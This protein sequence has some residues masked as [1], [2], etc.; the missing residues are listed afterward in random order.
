MEMLLQD[1]RYGLRILAKSPAFTAVAV[2]TLALGIGMTTAIFSVVYGVLLRPL[3][4]D[5]PEQIVQL[6][7]VNAQGRQMQF[8]DPNFEDVRSE[9]RTLQGAAEYAN[10]VLSVSGGTEPTRTMVGLVSR[11]F[12]PVLHVKPILGRGFSAEDQRF[13]AVP[14]ALLGYGYW[15]QFLGGTTDFGSKKLRID[16]RV[17][18]IIG[19][20]PPRF[21]FPPAAEIWVPREIYVR[22]PSRTA[23]NWQVIGR[24]RDGISIAEARAELQTIAT[25]LKQQYGQ[26]TMMVSVAIAPLL[27]AMTTDVRP[28]LWILLGAVGFLLLIA[29][30][31]VANLLL[32]QS[33]ARQHEIAVRFALGATR[34]RVVRQL[35]AEA[36]LLSLV[37]GMLGV[38]AAFWGLQ[39]LVALSPDVLPRLS[40]VSLSVPVLVFSMGLCVMVALALGLF[41]GLRS[42]S[43]LQHALSAGGRSQAGSLVSQ[44]MSRAI[45]AGQLAI[46][47]TLLAGAALLGRSLLRVL[48]I[49]PG[50]RTEHVIT[51]ELSLPGDVVLSGVDENNSKGRRVQFLDE[52]STRLRGIPGVEEV[53]GTTNLP[54]TG[55]HPD[56]TYIM[57]SPGET[58]PSNMQMLE[59]MFHDRSRTGYAEYSAVSDGYFRVL[60]IPLLRGRL[61]DARDT[62]TAPHVALISESL[63]QEKWPHEDPLG[64]QLEF[65]NMDG[66]LHL[67]TVVGVVGDVRADNLEHAA[68]P[69]IYVDYRQRPQ[70]TSS[71]KL[72]MRGSGDVSSVI[73]AARQI[74]RELDPEIPPKF[75]TLDQVVSGSVQG[76]RFNV[77]LLGVFAGTALLLALAG[78]YGVMAYSVT[79][80]TNEIGVRMALGASRTKILRLVLEQGLMTAAIGIA[81]GIVASV[82]VTRTISS[83][84]FGLSAMDPVTFVGVGLLLAAVAL[85]A[86]YI[87][88]RR[89]AK[90]DPMVALR[91]E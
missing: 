58:L 77:T 2:I 64:H 54:L 65:G 83:L 7:E 17:F 80:R 1:V 32:A 3:G 56:G 4:Y 66:D 59:Q 29:C 50:F 60:A 33:A 55:F 43:G 20:L 13:G 27:Q 36:L 6:H 12:L 10:V 22:Y 16:D 23:H 31:N 14:V 52:M 8:A 37:G 70:A 81:V 85:L 61:F 79:R 88:A 21:S 75:A 48:S 82:A 51:M 76:R 49:D 46:T 62:M 5:D 78:M 72:V 11:D 73:A 47:L 68:F 84:L 87:P 19:V 34:S 25:R 35:V 45:V 40:E 89:A 44:R 53:G 74:V 42:S 26:D 90:V 24:L 67:L 15:K 71:L 41:S 28:A 18:S 38:V 57:M 9:A 39:A 63:A 30:A 69:T 86:S 91:Y